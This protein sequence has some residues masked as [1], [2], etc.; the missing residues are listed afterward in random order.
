M[1]CREEII[2]NNLGLV[3]SCCKRF[4]GRGI[5]YDDLYQA[6]CLGLIKAVDNFDTSRGLMFSTYAV[7]VILGEI[8]RLF[9]DGGSVKVSRPLKELSLKAIRAS[10]R[11]S[12]ELGRAPQLSELAVRLG[13]SNEDAAEALCAAQPTMS[14]TQGQDDEKTEYD[15]PIIDEQEKLCENLSLLDAIKKLDDRDKDII[16]LRYQKELTQSKTAQILGMTQVQVSR[17]EKII[18]MKIRQLLDC[19]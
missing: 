11:M 15:I 17:R 13:V 18:L 3:H 6:G 8:K 19:V 10:E 4:K 5:E 7:P 9:R 12:K 2:T 16:K 1:I 14:L